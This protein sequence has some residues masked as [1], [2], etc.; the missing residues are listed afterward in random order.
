MNE[1]FPCRRSDSSRLAASA[2]LCLAT[3]LTACASRPSAGPSNGTELELDVPY[4]P[5]PQNVVDKMLEV[6]QIKSTD[7]VYDLGCGDGRIVITAALKYGAKGVGYDIDPKRVEESRWAAKAAGVQDLVRFEQKDIFAID[8]FPATVVTLYLLPNLNAK[9][10]PQ[11]EKLKPGSR[12]LSHD[13]D[14]EDVP[15]AGE[16]TVV[17][18]SPANPDRMRDHKVYLW[19]AP[20]RR[21]TGF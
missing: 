21:S 7:L 9:L 5:T 20:I 1:S 3:A 10:I 11:L 12:V 16:W 17:A 18:P 14:I 15:R 2:L 8:L 6:A 19:R 4:V 13:F